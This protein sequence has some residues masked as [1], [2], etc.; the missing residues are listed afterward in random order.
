MAD[1]HSKWVQGNLVFYDTYL[2][3]WL[4]AIGSG[5]TK[6]LEH[7]QYP[8]FASADT[9]AGWT[10]TL[11]EAGD[12]DTTLALVQGSDLGELLITTD[13]SEND[14]ANLQVTGEAFKL[15]SGKPCYFGCR[16]KTGEATQSDIFVGLSITNTNILGGVSDSIGF[17]K[18]DGSTTMNALLEKDATET[19]ATALTVVAN[20]YYTTEFFFDGTNVDFFVDGVQLTRPAM[21]N[22]PDDE[23]LTPSIHFLSGNAAAE[24]MTIDWIRCIQIN[25]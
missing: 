21:T 5:V 4:D 7:F 22:L 8:A 14:G 18:V 20:T 16:W 1:V 23:Y 10:T 13:G 11:V 25:G 3:R 12:G 24:T 9:L 19:T 15:A 17:R 2:Y 6:V